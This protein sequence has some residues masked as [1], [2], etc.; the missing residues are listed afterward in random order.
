MIATSVISHTWARELSQ[1]SGS[2][3]GKGMGKG[4]GG[5]EGYGDLKARSLSGDNL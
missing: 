5:K 4:W 2:I 1:L 3:R